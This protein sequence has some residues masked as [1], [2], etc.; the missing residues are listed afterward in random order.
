MECIYL[1][2]GEFKLSPFAILKGLSFAKS[3][4]KIAIKL[5]RHLLYMPENMVKKMLIEIV[6]KHSK[7]PFFRYIKKAKTDPSPFDI[8][9][10]DIA[11]IFKTTGKDTDAVIDVLKVKYEKDKDSI[12]PILLVMG[13]EKKIYTK[14]KV[15][16]PSGI[17]TIG[18]IKEKK[19]TSQRSLF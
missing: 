19:D 6:P 16:E 14:F 8:I 7:M 1:K 10:N 9:R 17:S 4:E 5:N 11:K 12:I 3:T 18:E 15:K 13:A 2:K